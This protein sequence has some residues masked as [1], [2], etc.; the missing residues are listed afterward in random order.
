[1][2]VLHQNYNSSERKRNKNTRTGLYVFFKIHHDPYILNPLLDN[3]SKLLIEPDSSVHRLGFQLSLSHFCFLP[4][5]HHFRILHKALS[6]SF[7]KRILYHSKWWLY[8][9]IRICRYLQNR[10]SGWPPFV[11]GLGWNFSASKCLAKKRL[12]ADQSIPVDFLQPQT[13]D[14]VCLAQKVRLYWHWEKLER[15]Y[16]NRA[17]FCFSKFTMIR[18]FESPILDNISNIF[19]EPDS[20]STDSSL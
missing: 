6:N 12:G 20:L 9:T 2:S 11:W 14:C 13:K 1:M 19:I 16:L 4:L 3:T 18:T 5:E 15:I 8:L 10:E 7:R 17:I